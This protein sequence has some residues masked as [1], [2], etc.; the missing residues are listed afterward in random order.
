MIAPAKTPLAVA[1]TY[2]APRAPRVV[3][4]GRGELGQRII[5]TAREHGVPLESNAPLAEAL[6]TIELESEIPEA[7][8]EAVAVIIGFIM[9][10]AEAPPGK[11]A[12]TL[13]G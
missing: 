7:L 12:T 9:R 10:A 1:L 5:D 4:I 13:R 8:Y 3:A 6:S 2:E 11:P